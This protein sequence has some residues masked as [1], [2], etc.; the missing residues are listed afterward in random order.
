MHPVTTATIE[1]RCASVFPAYGRKSK[2][3]A[4]RVFVDSAICYRLCLTD[5]VLTI[6]QAQKVCKSLS[7]IKFHMTCFNVEPVSNAARNLFRTVADI[8][9][10]GTAMADDIQHL[11]HLLA[12]CRIQSIARFI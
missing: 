9:Q 10:V 2:P 6:C 1:A 11:Q 4:S 7:H 5:C 12:I 3:P 8:K